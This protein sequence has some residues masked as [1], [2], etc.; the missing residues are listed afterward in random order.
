VLAPEFGRESAAEA[1][2]RHAVF[3]DS[4]LDYLRVRLDPD[5]RLPG[6][7]HPDARADR[8]IAAALAAKLGEP[9]WRGCATPAATSAAD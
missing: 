2:L 7:R 9:G 8:A 6:D 5:W 4:D 1:R 3:D